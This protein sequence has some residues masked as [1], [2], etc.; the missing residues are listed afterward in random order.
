VYQKPPDERSSCVKIKAFRVLHLGIAESY[1][2]TFDKRGKES[3][4]RVNGKVEG[5]D[6]EIE[7]VI[8]KK[9]I[10]EERRELHALGLDDRS[11]KQLLRSY[12]ECFKGPNARRT[13]GA[14]L[15]VCA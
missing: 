13:L 6:V 8:V 11:F 7:Y 12:V 4:R 5:Y 10:L 1:F 3:L 14:A 2:R 9:T 15:P